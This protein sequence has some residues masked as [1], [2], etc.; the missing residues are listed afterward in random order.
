MRLIEVD[1]W[2]G[3]NLAHFVVLDFL[4]WVNLW[5]K[6]GSTSFSS[7]WLW[8]KFLGIWILACVLRFDGENTNRQRALG[9]S[10]FSLQ[11]C[12]EIDEFL[13]LNFKQVNRPCIQN[14]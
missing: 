7:F 14:D 1:D 2:C 11:I 8:L 5:V 12:W 6:L 10:L 13:S 3:A 9:V 4:R